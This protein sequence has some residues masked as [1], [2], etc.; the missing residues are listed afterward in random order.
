MDMSHLLASLK[1]MEELH[2]EAM[3]RS[4]GPKREEH[5]ILSRSYREAIEYLRSTRKG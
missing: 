5:A 3:M 1:L 2:Y 4:S